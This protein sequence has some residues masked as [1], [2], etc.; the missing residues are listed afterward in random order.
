MN[1]SPK[2]TQIATVELTLTHGHFHE[3]LEALRAGARRMHACPIRIAAKYAFGRE[4]CVN[5]G[6]IYFNTTTSAINGYAVLPAAGA[7]LQVEFDN[8]VA[9]H[10]DPVTRTPSIVVDPDRYQA[11]TAKLPLTLQLEMYLP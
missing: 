3:S 7:D 8:A 6:A 5:Y 2:D 10:R 4:C 9:L 11:L 1:P